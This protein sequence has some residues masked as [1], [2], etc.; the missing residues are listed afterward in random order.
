MRL[1]KTSRYGDSSQRQS[2]LRKYVINMIVNMVFGFNKYS[3]ISDGMTFMQLYS[4]PRKLIFLEKEIT[5]I[6]FYI[7]LTVHHAMILGNCPT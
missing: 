1:Y 4:K 6:L 5:L 2:G 3:Q 7:L